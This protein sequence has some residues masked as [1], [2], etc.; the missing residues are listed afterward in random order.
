MRILNRYL[1]HDFLVAFAIALAIFT[2]V[3]CLGVVI[4][5][6]DVAAKGISAMLLFKVFA[7]NVP[8][9]LTFAIP[10]SVLTSLLIVF[11][12]LSFDGEITAMKACGVSLW[13]IA[14]PILVIAIGFSVLCLAI[15]TSIAPV[16]RWKFRALIAEAGAEDPIKLLEPGIF[17]RDFPGTMIY[18]GSRKGNEIRDVHVYVLGTNGPKQK[19]RAEYGKVRMDQ[20]N[21]VMVVDLFNVQND[22]LRKEGTGPGSEKWEHLYAQQYPYPVDLGRLLKRKQVGQK[23][24]E[25]TYS[26]IQEAVAD[27]A[28]AYPE[29]PGKDLEKRRMQLMVES[30]R[31]LALS[32]SCF[33]FALLAIP[34]GMKSRR[35]ESSIGILISLG[36]VTVFYLFILISSELTSRPEWR[37]DLIVWVPV[38]ATQLLGIGLIHRSR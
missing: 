37:P 36:V 4:K 38:L 3:M 14:A 28:A 11:G 1:L 25:M 31:R 2:G 7:Y 22:M 9:M 33:G 10:M 26:D 6:I 24:G 20:T 34:L 35:R 29:L 30:N 27:V 12:R 13:Q 19:I 15:N 5:A 18:V 17:V 16:L 21:A 32:S 8:F 23:I